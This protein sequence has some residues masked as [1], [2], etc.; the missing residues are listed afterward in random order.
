MAA[1]GRGGGR[2]RGRRGRRGGRVCGDSGGAVALS[3][4]GPLVC[5]A[6]GGLLLGCPRNKSPACL[7]FWGV[8]QI[9]IVTVLTTGSEAAGPNV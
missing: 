8:V 7:I 4:N 5:Q 1:A 3:M 9:T 6:Q 2:W